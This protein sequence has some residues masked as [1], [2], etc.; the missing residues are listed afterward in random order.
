MTNMRKLSEDAQR[1]AE[2]VTPSVWSNLVDAEPDAYVQGDIEDA[3]IAG[4]M[5]QDKQPVKITDDM[6][7]RAAEASWEWSAGSPF[8]SQPEKTKERYRQVVR[9]TI[10][11]ALHA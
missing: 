7:D 4:A 5:A 10:E 1:Y 6:V 3:Y 9:L 11:A 2:T 8:G